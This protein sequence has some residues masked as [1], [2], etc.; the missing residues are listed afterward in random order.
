MYPILLCSVT[1]LAIFLERLWNLRRHL[2]LPLDFAREIEELIRRGNIPDAVM[3][4]QQN[5]SS[6]ARILLVGIKNFGK[7]REVIKEHV[8]EVGR[9][10]SASLERFVEGLGTIAG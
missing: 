2:V 10:E 5:R 1:A 9:H 7:R 6:I 4:C 3:R 8:E